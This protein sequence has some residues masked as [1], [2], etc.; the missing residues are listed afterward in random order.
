MPD[1]L[2]HVTPSR[3]PDQH[4]LTGSNISTGSINGTLLSSVNSTSTNNVN[5]SN[6]NNLSVHLN[7][8]LKIPG[9]TG[10][11]TSVSVNKKVDNGVNVLMMSNVLKKCI[12]TPTV[13]TRVHN[14]CVTL[15]LANL[16]DMMLI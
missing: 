2:L 9:N 4:S 16:S 11:L 1:N 13:L 7:E 8:V 3:M 12:V 6:S 15:Q 10:L 5:T 14:N